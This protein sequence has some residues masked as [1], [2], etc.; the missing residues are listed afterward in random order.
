MLQPDSVVVTGMGVITPL[1]NSVPVFWEALLQQQTAIVAQEDLAAMGFKHIYAARVNELVSLPADR[2]FELAKR[3]IAQAMEQAKMNSDNV[4]NV[5]LI[6]GTTMGESAAFESFAEGHEIELDQYNGNGVAKKIAQHFKLLSNV[7]CIG[8]ACAAGNYA[9]GAAAWLLKEKIYQQIIAGG[10]EP[11]S[12]TAHVGFSRSRAMSATGCRPFDRSHDGMTLGE[13]AAFLVMELW[14]T[15]AKRNVLPLAEIHALGLSCDAFHPTAPNPDGLGMSRS[16]QSALQ[17]AKIKSD[18]IGWVCLH[19]SGTEASDAAEWNTLQLLPKNEPL[20]FAGYKGAIGHSLGAA[21]AIEAIV[22]I[23][24]LL[25]KIIPAS[26][27]LQEPFMQDALMAPVISNISFD[28]PYVLNS[29]YAFGGL[30]SALII[31]KV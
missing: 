21:S 16:I 3:A 28:K 22:C 25:H 20:H 4:A 6:I 12:K 2:G 24:S 15:A 18:D 31:G 1:G 30:N 10:V 7:T 26:A 27:G 13:G 19:G 14:E 11:F 17:L 23:Q 5:K 8:T 29:A 9:I